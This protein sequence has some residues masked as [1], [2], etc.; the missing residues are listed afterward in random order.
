M[1]VAR[2]LEPQ[3]FMRP[4]ENAAS[5]LTTMVIATTHTVTI[6]VFLKKI[7]KSVCV[8]RMLELIERDAVDDEPRIGRHARH[9]GVA[10]ERGDDH[11]IGRHQEEDREHDQEHVGRDQRPAAVAAQAACRAETAARRGVA[12]AA[13]LIRSPCRACA[14]RAG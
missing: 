5:T 3:N 4:S 2:M 14:R 12:M 7:R 13:V 11:V 1:P 9:L 10:L 8:S 6:T